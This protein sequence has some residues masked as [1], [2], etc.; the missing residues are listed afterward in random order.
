MLVDIKEVRDGLRI[1][2]A[3]PW[4]SFDYGVCD[5]YT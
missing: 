3:T 4:K 5:D 1:R 2:G